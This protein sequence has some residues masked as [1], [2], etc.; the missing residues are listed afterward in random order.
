MQRMKENNGAQSVEANETKPPGPPKSIVREYFE[1][2]VVTVIMAIFGMTF[3]IQAVKVPT[4]SMQNTIEIG[5]HF[6]VNKFAFGGG[7]GWSLPFLPQRGI[8]RGDIIVFKYPG[9]QFDE[10]DPFDKNPTNI[11]LKTNYVKRVIGL[12]GETVEFRA[13]KVYINGQPLPESVATV[14]PSR[15]RQPGAPLNVISA[16][17][18]KPGETHYAYYETR[19]MEAAKRGET[20]DPGYRFSYGQPYKIPDN[21]YFVM[22]DSRDN[23]QDSRFWGVVPRDHI[24]GRA[25]FIYWSYDETGDEGH[26][27]NTRWGRTGTMIK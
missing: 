9:N 24:F 5:D 18:L 3:V 26:F 19:T 20:P 14:T 27:L 17:P 2:A 6:L 15:E 11:P 25:M 23:S 22:G 8:R 16:A 13:A 12:P 1:S 4:G 10:N 7:G 21:C